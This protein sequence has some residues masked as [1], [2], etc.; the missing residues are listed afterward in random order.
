MR[1]SLL[2][3]LA[4][5]LLLASS[6]GARSQDDLRGVIQKAIKA[7]GGEEALAKVSAGRSKSKGTLEFGG[8][9]LP[10]TQDM[11][12]QLPGQFKEVMELEAGGQKIT[13]A[14]VFN[15]TKGWIEV[16]GK[17]QDLDDKLLTELKEAAHLMRLSRLTALLEDKNCKL[18]AAGEAKVNNKA[19]V[20][21]RVESKGFRDVNLYFDKGSGLLLKTE[22]RAVDPTTGQELNEER[23]ITEY[24]KIEGMES[25]K[26]VLVNRD[27]KKFMEA[28]VLEVKMLDKIDP[29]TFERPA[30]Q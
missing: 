24:H 27:G 23:I 2:V 30:S 10:F 13:V 6:E 17:I 8:N 20:G 18:T 7:H 4:V 3:M 9:S 21:V 29:K 28:E 14:T 25:P 15:G 16:N 11:V 12:Y 26:K 5:G 19:A 1:T 22:R